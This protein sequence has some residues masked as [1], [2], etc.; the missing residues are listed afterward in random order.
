M[1]TKHVLIGH[2]LTCVFV[3]HASVKGQHN[4][5]QTKLVMKSNECLFVSFFVFFLPRQ[6]EKLDHKQLLRQHTQKNDQMELLFHFRAK[7]IEKSMNS[8]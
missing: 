7:S 4:I 5:L 8:S 2:T 6:N 3:A 1:K